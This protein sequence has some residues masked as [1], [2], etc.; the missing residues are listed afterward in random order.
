MDIV[1]LNLRT[2]KLILYVLYLMCTC[3][4]LVDIPSLL[5][6]AQDI[7]NINNFY[8]QDKTKQNKT[9]RETQYTHL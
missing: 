9:K 2:S 6:L 3:R 5:H 7:T 4:Y 8:F 1:H